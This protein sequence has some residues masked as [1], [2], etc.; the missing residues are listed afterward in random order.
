[1]ATDP[2]SNQGDG[3]GGSV[4]SNFRPNQRIVNEFHT[5][6]DLDRDGSSHH[7]SLGLGTNQASSGAHNHDGTN[8]VQLLAGFTLT[9]S[10]ASGAAL[11]SVI[12][13]LQ[14]LGATDS[15]TA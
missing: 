11:I 8:S 10:R 14:Q 2:F 13:A 9:G 4:N 3:T 15:T 5:N 1:M 12:D 6:D 7:H